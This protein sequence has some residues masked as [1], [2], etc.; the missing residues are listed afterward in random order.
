[1]SL[2]DEL[3]ARGIATD[4]HF[5]LSS[6]LHAGTFL[7]CTL[8]LR[9]TAFAR[10]IGRQL[11]D[12]VRSAGAD[13]VATPGVSSMLLGFVVA[14]ALAVPLVWFED[15]DGTPALRRGQRVR[16]D[17]RVLVVEDV[18]TTG[19]SAGSVASQV[20]A[21]GAEVVGFATLVDR[22]TGDHP[23]PFEATSLVQVALDTSDP[24][25]CAQC[26]AGVPVTDPS[27]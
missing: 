4:G 19:R 14:D 20:R 5:A 6:G 26:E 11:A 15:R 8:A 7:Q 21:A 10:R 23:L 13:L 25:V 22:S 12:E 27:I 3:R 9:D 24:T 17:A 1:V 18:L 16:A 2:Y